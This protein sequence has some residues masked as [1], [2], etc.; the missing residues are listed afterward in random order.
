MDR[1]SWDDRRRGLEEEFF[2]RQN[3]ELVEQLKAERNREETC[4]Q[5]KGLTGIHDQDVLHRLYE[6]KVTPSTYMALTLVPLVTVA[7]IDG[8]IDAKERAAILKAADEQGMKQGELA[9]RLLDSWLE[10][11]PTE[12]LFAT[13]QSYVE[14]LKY[15]LD[16]AT[17]ERLHRKV[18]DQARLVANSTGGFLGLGSKVSATEQEALQK[19]ES[20]FKKGA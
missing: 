18:L 10:R 11:E 15:S 8:S 7:W 3:R 1:D 4:Q 14:G 6:A 12:Q 16:P 20:V 2:A 17:F 19:I 9:Y 13:W 5:L